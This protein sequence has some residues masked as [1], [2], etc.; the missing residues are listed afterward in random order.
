MAHEHQ[1]EPGQAPHPNQEKQMSLSDAVRRAEK[2]TDVLYKVMD[3]QAIEERLDP[4]PEYVGSTRERRFTNLEGRRNITSAYLAW[5][6]KEHTLTP[7][8]EQPSAQEKPV[9]PSAKERAGNLLRNVGMLIR[10]HTPGLKP[11]PVEEPKPETTPIRAPKK[12]PSG[13]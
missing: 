4:T 5:A 7:D 13:K 8:G 1:P 2:A 6:A 3:D 9:H 11:K 12:G 10:E